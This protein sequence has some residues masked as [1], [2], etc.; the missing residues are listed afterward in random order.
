MTFKLEV[1]A[2]ECSVMELTALSTLFATLANPNAVECDA[3][4]DGVEE[5]QEGSTF[6]SL[7]E[8]EEK[9]ETL[10]QM[11]QRQDEEKKAPVDDTTDSAGF[12]WDER[13]HSGA[14]SVNKDGTWKLKRGVDKATVDEIRASFTGVEETQPDPQNVGFSQANT[15]SVEI[16][17]PEVLKRVTQAKTAGTIDPASIDAAH[18]ALGVD[19]FVLLANRTDLHVPFLASLGLD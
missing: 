5:E 6:D 8:K 16:T 19:A 3:V 2:A 12:P 18:K 14:K 4:Y 17:W 7:P 13:I 1:N 11:L 10:G 15:P 9:G